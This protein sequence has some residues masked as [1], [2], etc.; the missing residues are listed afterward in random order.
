M[1]QYAQLNLLFGRLKSSSETVDEKLNKYKV[2]YEEK[3]YERF[4]VLFTHLRWNQLKYISS[5]T[6]RH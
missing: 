3:K 2:F 4:S 1:N 5:V 6:G